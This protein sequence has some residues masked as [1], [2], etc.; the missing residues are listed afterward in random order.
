[1][2][3]KFDFP[4]KV[5]KSGSMKALSVSLGFQRNKT[6]G[7]LTYFKNII[8]YEFILGLVATVKTR[9]SIQNLDFCLVCRL[10]WFVCLKYQRYKKL[11]FATVPL[12]IHNWFFEI[13]NFQY[14]NIL[15][16]IIVHTNMVFPVLST[17]TSCL[18]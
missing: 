17:S 13:L 9:F 10:L 4:A 6:M 7:I 12:E 3:Y 16:L 14:Y 18:N 2:Q 11:K 5:L 15:Q 1:M 8:S